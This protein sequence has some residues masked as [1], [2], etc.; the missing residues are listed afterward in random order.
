MGGQCVFCA[1]AAGGAP[2]H[3]VYEDASVLAFLD[4]R[5][6]RRGH[7][8]VIPRD[9][10]PTLA[11]LPPEEGCK[12]FAVA[13]RV[14]VALRAG[15]FA[16]DGVN[17]VVNDGKAAFQTVPHTH[18]H[19]VPRHRNDTLGFAANLALRRGRALPEVARELR[20]HLAGR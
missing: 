8:L 14:A 20:Q 18:V 5:P 10:H 11:D 16:A 9:H 17:V 15:T 1:I 6:L 4:I 3:L 12:V 2:A 19:V 13:H 7:T